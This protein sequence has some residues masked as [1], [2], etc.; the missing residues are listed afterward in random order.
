MTNESNQ[1]TGG[2]TIEGSG[3]MSHNNIDG[4]ADESVIVS[5]RLENVV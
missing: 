2:I 1:I 3:N 4:V 5:S